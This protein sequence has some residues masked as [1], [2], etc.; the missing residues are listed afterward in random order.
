[1]DGVLFDHPFFQ[2]G[3]MFFGELTCLLVYFGVYF[4]RRR[5]WTSRHAVGHSGAAFDLDDEM[6][7]EPTLPSFN[8]WIFLPPGD[9]H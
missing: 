1:M 4:V 6:A 3:C 8:T 2:A 9:R 5:I 7:E